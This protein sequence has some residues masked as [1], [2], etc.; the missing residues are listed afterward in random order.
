M[1]IKVLPQDQQTTDGITT[2]GVKIQAKD[3]QGSVA[4]NKKTSVFP[5]FASAADL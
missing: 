5:S 3:I 1:L 4:A 2:I